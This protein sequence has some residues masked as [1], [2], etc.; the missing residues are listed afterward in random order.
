MKSNI[1]IPQEV[2]VEVTLTPLRERKIDIDH[3]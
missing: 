1:V 2:V 3:D